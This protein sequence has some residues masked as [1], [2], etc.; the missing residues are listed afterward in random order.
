MLSSRP[1]WV[2]SRLQLLDQLWGTDKIVV[3]RTID[4]HIKNLRDKNGEYAGSIKNVR[5]LGYKYDPG[6]TPNAQG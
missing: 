1:G 6:D 4:V 2:F 5:G 3:E